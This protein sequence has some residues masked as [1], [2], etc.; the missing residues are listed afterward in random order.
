MV[1]LLHQTDNK[2]LFR[3]TM[4]SAMSYSYRKSFFAT[5]TQASKDEQLSSTLS[6]YFAK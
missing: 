5:R 4:A 2:Y 3:S 1:N 6:S